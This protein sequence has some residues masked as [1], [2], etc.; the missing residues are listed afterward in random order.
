MICKNVRKE[1]LK[2]SKM[3]DIRMNSSEEGTAPD[4]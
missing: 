4:R 2:T 1:T 3:A